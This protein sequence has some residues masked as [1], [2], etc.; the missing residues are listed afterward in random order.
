MDGDVPYHSAAPVRVV[1]DAGRRLELEVE[2]THDL[3]S[4]TATSSTAGPS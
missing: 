3:V 2:E 4:A 1:Q